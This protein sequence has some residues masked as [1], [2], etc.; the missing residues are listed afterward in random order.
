MAK[1][2]NIYTMDLVLEYAKI[3]PENADMGNEQGNKF[4]KEL[5]KN[6][7]Q[8]IV[9]GYFTSEDQI[10][11]LIKGGMDLKPMGNDRVISGNADLGI[12]K[13]LKLKRKVWDLKTFTNRNGEEVEIQY[14]GPPKV[15]NLT[16][17]KE[18]KSLW[19]YHEDGLLGNGTKA[20]VQFELFRDGVGVRLLNVGVTEHVAYEDN[21]VL[22]EDDELFIV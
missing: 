14:G 21:N 5:A 1:K 9:N 3:F 22:T 6:G 8:F 19:S 4:Q 7:G 15:V 18:N 12:G 16:E 10:S 20:K 11:A 2:E 17:G 13:Y